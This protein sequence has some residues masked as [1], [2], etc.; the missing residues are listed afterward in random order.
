MAVFC[1]VFPGEL[2]TKRPSRRAAPFCESARLRAA[3]VVSIARPPVLSTAR[4]RRDLGVSLVVV[5]DAHSPL[6]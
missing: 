4:S 6:P 2:C 1:Y 3:P 5:V